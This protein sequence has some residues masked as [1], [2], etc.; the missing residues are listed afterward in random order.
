M[1]GTRF[2]IP[3]MRGPAPRQ[4]T[5]SPAPLMSAPLGDTPHS[6]KGPCLPWNPLMISCYETFVDVLT[7]S[8]PN[9]F[10]NAR[11]THCVPAPMEVPCEY[12]R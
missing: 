10:D 3:Q 5:S 7:V 2:C 12:S 11:F 6:A 4:V 9:I 1:S 8:G